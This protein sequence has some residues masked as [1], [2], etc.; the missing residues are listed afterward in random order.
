MDNVLQYALIWPGWVAGIGIGL[1]MLLTYWVTGRA[2]GASRGYCAIVALN[3]KLNFFA[4]RRAEFNTTRIW[5]LL[6]IP[7]GSA[8]A[9]LSSP[10]VEW[11]LTTS[12]GNYYDAMLPASPWLKGLAIFAG[13][14][15]M[16]A[17][18]RMAGG[19][20]SGNVIVGVSHLSPPSMVSGALFF[21][22]GLLTVQGLHW[23]TR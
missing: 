17:G 14:V 21:A 1:L 7:L 19:C 20:T 9:V 16:G 8:I 23:L 10:G 4:K 22:G 18:A 15:L 2:L 6:G 13:G 11:S 12:M 5:F 3:S